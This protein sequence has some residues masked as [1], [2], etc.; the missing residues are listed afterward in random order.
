MV[1]RTGRA[2]LRG[3]NDAASRV[4]QLDYRVHFNVG[5]TVDL[6]WWNVLLKTWN[7]VIFNFGA[8]KYSIV[9]IAVNEAAI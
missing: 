6:A 2:F 5:A 8:S 7:G 3:L 4:D 1:V 9:H